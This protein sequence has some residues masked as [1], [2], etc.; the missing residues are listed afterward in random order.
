MSYV[1]TSTQQASASNNG[2]KII[3]LIGAA[4]AILFLLIS[5]GLGLGAR[6][7]SQSAAEAQSDAASMRQK[8]KETETETATTR[9]KVNEATTKKE[10]QDW[11]SGLTSEKSDFDSLDEAARKYDS[12]TATRRE[13]IGQ[14]CPQKQS[15]IEA[16]SKDMSQDML[17]N[18]VH[19]TGGASTVTITGSVSIVG[20]NLAGASAYDV[21]VELYLVPGSSSKGYTPS[22]KQTVTVPAGGTG[23]TT[24]VV[25]IPSF[26]SG[27][28][29]IRAVSLWPS[30]L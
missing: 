27:S 10:A 17:H 30:G 7:N 22:D 15:F 1:P 5:V 19:C 23:T 4:V 28:C 16:Y 25:P 20:A 13:A 24:S 9:T 14:I 12:L 18:D 8:A 11:C 21:G 26:N 2:S 6:S 3:T 29:I